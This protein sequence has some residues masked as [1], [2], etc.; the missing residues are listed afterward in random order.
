M[1][2]AKTDLQVSV[3]LSPVQML[4]PQL[5]ATV[6]GILRESGLSAERL[7][8]EITESTLIE[9]DAYASDVIA[10][11]RT[12]GIRISL[13]DFG[14]GYASVGYVQR[15]PLD[16][17][18]IDRSLI[19]PIADCARSREVA[20]AIIALSRAFRVL[21][22]AEGVETRTQADLLEAMGCDLLQGWYIGRPALVSDLLDS[23]TAA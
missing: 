3:N 4:D 15:F 14:S 13:D 16:K 5:I 17:I 21:V 19:S 12:L 1:A 11:L 7:E 9:Q 18:K 20:A 23:S 6:S 22:T 8:L 10:R 2:F